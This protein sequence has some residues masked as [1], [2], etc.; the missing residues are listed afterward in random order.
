[1]SQPQVESETTVLAPSEGG[2]RQRTPEEGSQ[3]AALERPLEES[4]RL[5][6]LESLAENKLLGQDYEVTQADG[7][8][9]VPETDPPTFISIT[10]DEGDDGGGTAVSIVGTNLTGATVRTLG[11]VALTSVVVVDDNHI[12]GVTGAHAVG[13]VDLVITTP[14]GTVTA[15][16][17]F[18]YKAL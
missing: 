9:K 6:N 12:T 11:G 15:D 5:A 1:M 16:D 3:P 2:T 10:P 8:R 18:E 14:D 17:V 4:A 7:W 13:L